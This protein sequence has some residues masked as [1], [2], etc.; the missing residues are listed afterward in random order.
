[1]DIRGDGLVIGGGSGIGRAC[2]LALAR[3]GAA[4]V[5]IADINAEAANKVALEA[6]IANP[7]MHVEAAEVDVTSEQSIDQLLQRYTHAFRRLDYFIN[8]AGIG[9]QKAAQVAEADAA[10]FRRFMDINVTGT[11]L[12]TR[13]ASAIMMA[14]DPLPVT[15]RVEGA[16]P[17]G[18]TRGVIVLMGSASSFVSTPGMVQ[19]TTSKHAVLGIAK[20]S[21]LDNAVHNIRVNSVCPSWVDTPMVRQAIDTVPG[22]EKMIENAVPMRRMATPEEIADAVMFLCSPRSSFITGCGLVIDGGTTLTSKV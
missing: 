9:V 8:C 2:A 19:Y 3:E 16:L 1:M 7:D 12:A 20:N 10:E 17:R 4:G 11:L 13:A 22:L 14:Q 18:D 6:R 5:M 21:A 15:Q